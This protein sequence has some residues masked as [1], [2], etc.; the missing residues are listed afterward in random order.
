MSFDFLAW[1]SRCP[2]IFLVWGIPSP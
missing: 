1:K 2:E